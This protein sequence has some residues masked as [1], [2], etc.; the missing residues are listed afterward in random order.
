MRVLMVLLAVSVA[1]AQECPTIRVQEDFDLEV[2][3]SKRWYVQEQMEVHYLPK[4]Q[5]NCVFAEYQQLSKNT[6]WGFN[7]QVHNYAYDRQQHKSYDS[8]SFI[9]AKTTEVP[10]KLNVG[11]CWFPRISG[12]TTGAYWVLRHDEDAGYAVIIGGQPTNRSAKGCSTNHGVN[13]SGLWIFTRAQER[14]QKVVDLAREATKE[15]ELD[16]S[17]LNQVDQTN[18]TF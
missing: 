16:L 4:E 12:W 13:N 15:F 1:F 6:F 5:N 9:C 14:D 11:P 7:I 3:A 17:V 10:A 18:C 8:G 2:Y